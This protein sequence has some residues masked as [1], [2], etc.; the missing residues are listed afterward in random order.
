[1]SFKS[2]IQEASKRKDGNTTRYMDAKIHTR[3]GKYPPPPYLLLIIDN[4]ASDLFPRRI[5]AFKVRVTRTTASAKRSRS[6][7]IPRPFPSRAKSPSR[8]LLR[9]IFT[10][11]ANTGPRLSKGHAPR[12]RYV[13]LI[14]QRVCVRIIAYTISYMRTKFSVMDYGNDVHRARRYTKARHGPKIRARGNGKRR[15]N[16]RT[17]K[18]RDMKRERERERS[19]QRGES[20]SNFMQCRRYSHNNNDDGDEERRETKKDNGE[21]RLRRRM[22]GDAEETTR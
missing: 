14:P 18:R 19:E 11:A 3:K 8:S 7:K 13:A 21:R 2:T 9:D 5:I 4:K 6:C 20:F 22:E 12:A 1:M 10:A 15:E 17:D 16:E